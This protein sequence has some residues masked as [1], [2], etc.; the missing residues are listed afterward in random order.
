MNGRLSLVLGVVEAGVGGLRE[1]GYD[2]A[3]EEAVEA[4]VVGSEADLGGDGG[5]GGDGV[6]ADVGARGEGG[7][8]F[9]LDDRASAEE[10]EAD[11][12]GVDDA[13]EAGGVGLLSVVHYR[14]GVKIVEMI[15]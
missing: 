10:L 14:K 9:G 13:E 6:G 3:A 2:P 7:V 12:L 1:L 15:E 11:L 4:R 8:E 5:E